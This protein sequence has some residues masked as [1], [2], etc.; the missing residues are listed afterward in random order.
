MR[1]RLRELEDESGKAIRV[2][3]DAEMAVGHH[4]IRFLNSNGR[5]VKPKAG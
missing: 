1:S 2:L 5:E 3:V 4:Q